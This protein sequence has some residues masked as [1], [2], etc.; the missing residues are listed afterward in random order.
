MHK[1]KFAPPYS[2]IKRNFEWWEAEYERAAWENDQMS[3]ETKQKWAQERAAMD[4]KYWTPSDLMK[5][6]HEHRKEWK[7]ETITLLK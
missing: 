4:L 7:L 6:Y 3:E 2:D 1:G 5:P